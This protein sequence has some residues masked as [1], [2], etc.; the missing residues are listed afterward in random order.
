MRILLVEDDIPLATALQKSLQTEG[1]VVNHLQQGKL[2]L[3]ALACDD[4]DMMILDLGLPD[5]DGLEILKQLREKKSALP[6]IILTARDSIESKVKGLDYGADDYLTKPFEIKELM[7]RLRVIERRL[8]TANTAFICIDEVKLDTYAHKV[9]VCDQVTGKE[10]EI[11]FTKKEYMVLKALME[12]AGRILSREKIESK[13]YHWGEEVLSNAVEVH[14]HKLRKY[15]PEKFIKN[16][17]GV[18]YIINTKG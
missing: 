5:I 18:G 4:Q 11:T 10:H 14:I 15:L 2:A 1:F 3:S 6:V 17:R 9:F 7:A 13:L 16:V 8:G 12:N